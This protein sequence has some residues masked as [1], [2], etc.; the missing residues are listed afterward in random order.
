LFLKEEKGSVKDKYEY[1]KSAK[2]VGLLVSRQFLVF[3]WKK[4]PGVCHVEDQLGLLMG[5][6]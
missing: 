5:Y 4:Q 3:D 6:F 2:S 1:Y